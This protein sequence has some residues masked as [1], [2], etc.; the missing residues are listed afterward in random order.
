MAAK[1]SGVTPYRGLASLASVSEIAA[2]RADAARERV[3]SLTL[4]LMAAHD[5]GRP[6]TQDEIVDRLEVDDP[7]SGR[8]VAAY[9]GSDI[10]I[11]QKFER[12]KAQIRDNGLR[13]SSL[14][15]EDQLYRYSLDPA[16]TFAPAVEFTDDERRVVALALRFCGFGREGAL[17]LFDGGAP[18]P[19]GLQYSAFYTPVVRAIERQAPVSFDYVSRAKVRR[20]EVEPL[21]IRVIE[22]VSYLVARERDESGWRVK[23]YRFSR[24]HS[25]PAVGEGHIAASA[26]ERALARVWQPGFSKG[27]KPVD[28]VVS[29]TS[30]FAQIVTRLHPGAEVV[31]TKKGRVEIGLVFDDHYQALRFVL[32]GGERLRLIAPSTLVK[33]LREWL[34]SVNTMDAPDGADLRFPPTTKRSSLGQTLAMLSAIHNS[35]EG[36]RISDLAERFDMSPALVRDLMGRLATFEIA[37]SGAGFVYH[38]RVIK[39]CEDWDHEETDDS[40]YRV[41]YEPGDAEAPTL[42]WAHL[43]E[44]NVALRE[45][46]GLVRD[47][48]LYSAMAKIEEIA[49]EFVEVTDPHLDNLAELVAHAITE[50]QALKITYLSPHGTEFTQRTVEPRALQSLNGRILFRAYCQ[51]REGWRTFRLD[52]VGDVLAVSPALGGRPEDS[53]REWLSSTSDDGVEVT[54]VADVQRRYLFESLPHAE[55]LP[56]EEGRVAVRFRVL[57]PGFLDRLM[58]MAGPGARVVSSTHSA[59]GRELAERW[60]AQI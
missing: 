21:V 12:D 16:E 3:A 8:R 20:R 18:T 60:R 29:T 46:T 27:E 48:A 43:F 50:N 1:R 54:V 44:L 22:G 36:L 5:S 33:A 31:T 37:D 26:D 30:E 25:M 13:L 9:Q 40:T 34:K 58:I 55:V 17:A 19:G 56:L 7:A 6:L 28:V 52:R 10:A 15:G 41:T 23:G 59:A 24:M 38:A 14:Q 35:P 49:G 4:L 53:E 39:E 51:L 32:E 11:R 45:A 42:T 57:D 2:S 47:P